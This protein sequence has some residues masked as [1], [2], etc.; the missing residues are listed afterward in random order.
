MKR[1]TKGEQ[2]SDI[3]SAVIDLMRHSTWHTLRDAAEVLDK[4]MREELERVIFET[5]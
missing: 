2:A 3:A 1:R 4:H 5:A